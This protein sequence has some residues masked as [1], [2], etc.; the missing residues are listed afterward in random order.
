VAAIPVQ[1]VGTLVRYYLEFQDSNTN[2]QKLPAG[3]ANAP[4]SFKTFRQQQFF[5]DGFEVASGWVSQQVAAQNDWHNQAP[6]NA[7]HAWDPPTA[8]EGTKCWGNDLSPPGSNGNY[9]NNVNN[10]LTSPILDC[11]GQ[12]NVSIVYRRWLTV[13]DG[14]YD[15]ARI[16][17]SNNN[18]A[19]YTTVWENPPGTGTQDFID[20]S[21][22]EHRVQPRQPVAVY[23]GPIGRRPWSID[24]FARERQHHAASATRKQRPGR[25]GP[26]DLRRLND[27][28]ILVVD[29]VSATSFIAGIGT[30]C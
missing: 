29:G 16:R 5:Y 19:T 10:N 14:L 6:N 28:A 30:I 3:G 12:S 26:S 22:V 24:A 4:F 17:V 23:G 20:T 15:H 21:W 1:P 27:A 13:E 7:N 9:A 8:F 11:T 18:G 25:P 2:T